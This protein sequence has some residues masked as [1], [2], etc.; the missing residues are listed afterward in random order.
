[1]SK[2]ANEVD[3]EDLMLKWTHINLKETGNLHWAAIF[4][5]FDVMDTDDVKKVVRAQLLGERKGSG[6]DARELEQL[7]LR[8]HS[9]QDH[10]ITH[11]D[12]V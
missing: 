10:K 1:M 5:G 2:A 7:H 6:I 8:R 9:S 11:V 3:T 4:I 12:I